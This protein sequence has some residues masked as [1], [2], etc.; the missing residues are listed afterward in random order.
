MVFGNSAALVSSDD[1]KTDGLDQ[2]Y[3]AGIWTT[4]RTLGQQC[5]NFFNALWNE[6]V[7]WNM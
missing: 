6:S 7:E 4:N 3:E 2:N 5:R 1:P